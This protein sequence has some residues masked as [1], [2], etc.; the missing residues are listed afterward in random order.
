MIR[1][2]R[3][4]LLLIALAWAALIGPPAHAQS[5]ESALGHYPVEDV[6]AM[7]GERFEDVVRVDRHNSIDFRGSEFYELLSPKGSVSLATDP[8]TLIGQALRRFDGK[9]V[10]ITIEPVELQELRR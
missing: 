10:R 1:I 2:H 3:L 9:R 6:V 7:S 8:K 5:I 4:W